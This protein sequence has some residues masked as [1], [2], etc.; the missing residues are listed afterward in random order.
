M[1]TIVAAPIAGVVVKR[2]VQTGESVDA[3]DLLLV[4][5]G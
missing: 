4:I 1:Q 2:L 3:K 5:E